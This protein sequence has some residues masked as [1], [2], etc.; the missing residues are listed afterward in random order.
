MMHKTLQTTMNPS[1][2][3]EQTLKIALDTMVRGLVHGEESPDGFNARFWQATIRSLRAKRIKQ[4]SRAWPILNK[5]LKEDLY[6]LLE[7]YCHE[8]KLP[9]D[10]N[11][12]ADGLNFVKWLAPKNLLTPNIKLKRMKVEL[13][14]KSMPYGLVPR[15]G[16]A[17][18]ILFL[19]NPARIAIGIKIQKPGTFLLKLPFAK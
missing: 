19:K 4:L 18:R 8:C 1:A 6:P 17:F 14:Y 15:K 2:Q 11:P 12:L 7:D 9:A 3:D 10:G 13:L 16:L 5:E